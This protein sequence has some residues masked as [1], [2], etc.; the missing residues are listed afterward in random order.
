MQVDIF[1]FLASFWNVQDSIIF[2]FSCNV[3]LSKIHNI[4]SFILLF[5]EVQAYQFCFLA[6]F[7]P[8]LSLSNRREE[9]NIVIL[10]LLYQFPNHD[11][12]KQQKWMSKDHISFLISF[13][14]FVN[15]KHDKKRS[16][17]KKKTQVIIH[18]LTKIM[19]HLTKRLLIYTFKPTSLQLIMHNFKM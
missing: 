3:K 12:G 14:F 19:I 10:F 5:W 7:A 11:K 4:A 6:S 18:E 8:P 9:Y 2:A 16:W 13:F 15:R 17:F 1:A